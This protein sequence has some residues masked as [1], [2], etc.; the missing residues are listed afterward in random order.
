MV[1][2]SFHLERLKTKPR[3]FRFDSVLLADNLER[4]RFD[5]PQHYRL[6]MRL[7]V[8]SRWREHL[9]RWVLGVRSARCLLERP[10]TRRRH[11]RNELSF[12]IFR[13]SWMTSGSDRPNCH[14]MASKGVRSSQAISTIRS[15]SSVVRFMIVQALHLNNHW[16]TICFWRVNSTA[17]WPITSSL[18]SAMLNMDCAGFAG[19]R[20]NGL[21]PAKNVRL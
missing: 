21:P 11:R 10:D 18:G 15:M 4:S 3:G 1:V 2:F 9:N 19:T 16:T 8:I 5:G 20:E 6:L 13:M 14:S 12:R 7:R 17:K